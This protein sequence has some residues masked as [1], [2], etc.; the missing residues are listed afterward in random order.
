[1]IE[2][3][4]CA[5]KKSRDSTFVFFTSKWSRIKDP[6]EIKK[7]QLKKCK[8]PLVPATKTVNT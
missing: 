8:N 3:M 1:M 7:S 4:E 6:I 5:G 2:R